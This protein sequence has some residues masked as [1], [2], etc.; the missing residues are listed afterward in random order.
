MFYAWI[1]LYLKI[2]LTKFSISAILFKI[3]FYLYSVGYTEFQL[4]I[5]GKFGIVS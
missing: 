5:S 4:D 1:F 3:L 2:S